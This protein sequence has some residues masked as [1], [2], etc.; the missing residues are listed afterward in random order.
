MVTRTTSRQAVNVAILT[1][2]PEQDL[3]KMSKHGTTCPVCAPYE[4]RVYSKSGENPDYPPLSAIFGKIDRAGPEALT[5]SYLNIHP[6]CLVPGGAILAESVMTHSCREYK[7]PVITLETSN[8][9]RITVTPNHLILTTEKFVSA[10]ALQKGYKIIETTRKY[11]SIHIL[12]NRA[13]DFNVR[14]VL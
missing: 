7:G 12:R 11:S 6:N 10:G 2:N 1:K 14:R 5:N 8:G 9:N 13:Y 3:F 4:G